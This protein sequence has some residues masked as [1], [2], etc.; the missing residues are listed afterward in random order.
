M[1]LP[2]RLLQNYYEISIYAL[3]MD[4]SLTFSKIFFKTHE[5]ALLFKKILGTIPP[6]PPSKHVALSRAAWLHFQ[7]FKKYFEPAPSP[8]PP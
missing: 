8:P 4:H 7:I 3:Y 5:I 2:W 1:F 6:N